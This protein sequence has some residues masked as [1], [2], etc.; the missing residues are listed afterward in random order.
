[1]WA[2]SDDPDEVLDE[3]PA[4]AARNDAI[5]ALEALAA[6]GARLDADVYR[7]TA[8]AWAATC[9]RTAALHTLLE[10]GANVNARTTFG[11]P[12]HGE[13]TT[14]LHLAAQSGHREATGLLLAAG[15]DA[16]ARDARHDATPAEWAA[17]GRHV[18]LRAL[19]D[20]A[21]R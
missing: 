5:G 12:D 8:L 20:E 21:A 11:G 15:A 16:T 1:V 4:W 3:A 2:P 19:L 18:E 10:L 13:A 6:A 9:G 14:A 7:G 17:M